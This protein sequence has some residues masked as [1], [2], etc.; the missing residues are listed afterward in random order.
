MGLY[1]IKTKKTWNDDDLQKPYDF[2][3]KIYFKKNC[4]PNGL[5]TLYKLKTKW[6]NITIKNNFPFE[7]TIKDKTNVKIIN[8]KELLQ[9]IKNSEKLFDYYEKT[10]LE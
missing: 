2:G 3:K 4:K 9:R 10:A 1:H 5:P 6:S 8:K 7:M